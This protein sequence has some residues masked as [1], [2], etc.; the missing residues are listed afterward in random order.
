M[1]S[2]RDIHTTTE[3]KPEMIAGV[4][5]GN[6]IPHDKCDIGGI[7]HART[8]RKDY[9]F[10]QR[11]LGQIFTCILE[12]GQ[13]TCKKSKPYPARAYTTLVMLVK[14]N[15]SFIILGRP[16]LSSFSRWLC[17]FWA[18]RIFS[19]SDRHS[20]QL[21]FRQSTGI[22]ISGHYKQHFFFFSVVFLSQRRSAQIK[23]L[24]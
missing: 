23:K 10:M 16:E 24:I 2:H 19:T 1:T 4:L 22:D 12:R 8:N 7:A 14:I 15:D 18:F 21:A 13:V 9:I 17:S 6:G 11:R 20:S 5:T 3:V